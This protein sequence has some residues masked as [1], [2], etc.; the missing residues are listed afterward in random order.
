M[1]TAT[2]KCDLARS[3]LRRARSN[4]RRLPNAIDE[5]EKDAFIVLLDRAEILLEQMKARVVE[6]H[7]A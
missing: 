3:G 1:T 7:R 2:H 4:V 6:P 5:G